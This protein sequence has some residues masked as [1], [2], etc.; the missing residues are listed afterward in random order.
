MNAAA[1][2]EAYT[3][4][5]PPWRTKALPSAANRSPAQ[6]CTDAS[7]QR[8]AD[9]VNSKT[10]ATRRRARLEEAIGIIR[11]E[12]GGLPAFLRVLVVHWHLTGASAL[13]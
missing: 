4:S 13:S 7:A 9:D 6:S 12:S 11:G 8:R 3:P 10:T 5:L 2:A 1:L